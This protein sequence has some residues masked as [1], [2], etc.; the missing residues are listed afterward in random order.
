MLLIDESAQ[1]K[2]G[3]QSVAVARQYHGRLGKTD[4]CQ[5]GVYSALALET[6]ATLTGS[7][8][9]L[10]EEWVKDRARCLAAGIP[11]EEIRFRTKLELAREL[12]AEALANGLEFGWVGVDAG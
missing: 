4:N 7:R 11:A 1:G 6:R 3:D 10:P 2:K 9:Y 12:V 8:L 5:A